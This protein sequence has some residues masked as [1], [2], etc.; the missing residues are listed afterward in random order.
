MPNYSL[1]LDVVSEMSET[2]VEL[3]FSEVAFC[4]KLE[5]RRYERMIAQGIDD[6]MG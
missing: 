5:A 2:R 1:A 3:R 6:I 4:P